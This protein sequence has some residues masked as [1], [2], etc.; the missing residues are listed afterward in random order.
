VFR[1]G[2]WRFSLVVSASGDRP[3]KGFDVPSQSEYPADVAPMISRPRVPIGE[4]MMVLVPTV[5]VSALLAYLGMPLL[6]RVLASLGLGAVLIAGIAYFRHRK[7][8]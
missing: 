8:R 6:P 2:S 1:H 4:Q 7:R 5:A 3:T